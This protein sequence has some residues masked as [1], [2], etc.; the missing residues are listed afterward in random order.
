MADAL[1]DR[2]R[3]VSFD[4]RGHGHSGTPPL[5]AD[6]DGR[7]PAMDWGCFAEDA[8]AVI[9]GLGL[10]RP[11]AFGHSCGGAVLLLAE[12]RR[13][14]TFT[15]IYAYEPVV[16]P[17]EF[18]ARM[19]G[20]P[21]QAARRRRRTFASK[22]AALEHFSAKP[23]LSSLRGDVLVDY[24]DG[25]FDQDPGGTVGLRCDPEAE[26]ATYA[27]AVHSEAWEHLGEV[28]CP[29]TFGCGRGRADFGLEVTTA[30]A[31]RMQH[32]RVETHPDLGHLGPF[33]R[34]EEVADAVGRAFGP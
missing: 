1:S 26:A 9:D 25:G 18:W 21:S 15:A 30:L 4:A 6:A 32:G 12:Q 22:A 3:V 34:P 17:P 33:E 16:A 5:E 11:L 24:V 28:G 8:L 20:D 19:D 29:V 27:M 31:A 23:P 2:Y 7:V 14:G 13:P 10:A